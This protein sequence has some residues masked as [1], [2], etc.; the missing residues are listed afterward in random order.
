VIEKQT[1]WNKRFPTLVGVSLI[2]VGII[3]TTYLAEIGVIPIIGAAPGDNPK[4][5]RVTNVSNSS[6]T[7]TYTTD[8]SVVGTVS[9]LNGA[10][11]QLFIDDRDG[12][13]PLPHFL[14]TITLKNLPAKT[15]ISYS[16][17]SGKSTY[18][19]Q[20]SPFTQTTADKISQS[21]SDSPPITG[22]TVEIDGSIPPES[23]VYIT[24]D[25]GQNISTYSNSQG[26]YATNLFIRSSNFSS[27]I[28]FQD[29]TKLQLLALGPNGRQSQVILFAKSS[30]P[31][32]TITLSQNYDFT[33]SETPIASGSALPI[34]FPLFGLDTTIQASESPKIDVPQDNETFTDSMPM[35]HGK[36]L[37]NETVSIVIHSD[38][39]I[40][41]SV[42]ADQYGNWSYQPAGS[43][44]PGIHTISITSK[45][46]FGILKTI[47]K[48][49]TILA[50]GTQVAEAA[51]PSA[52]LTPGIPTN[53]PTLTI[54]PTTAVSPT[55][56]LS[57]TAIPSI[58]PQITASPSSVFLSPTTKIN[59]SPT[60]AI[61]SAGSNYGIIGGVIGIVTT[62]LGLAIV[63]FT[64]ISL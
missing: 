39:K 25:G 16:I 43:L 63:L 36:V 14:H 3:L 58:T 22:K 20:S 7:V 24:T 33:Q 10:P 44:S 34:G 27:A 9:V 50:S 48:T 6:F 62:F 55:V 28:Q 23:L 60:K 42:T 38:E 56:S 61:P 57:I 26:L 35:L 59:P 40:S 32:P 11:S 64:H 30:N 54:A 8:Q 17:L 37:P 1:F 53:T 5:I 47:V 45:D 29:K 21:P 51:T 4:N 13:S 49:F 31:V 18:L 2:V 46:Q 41:T 19:N 15:T 12:Q 52:T